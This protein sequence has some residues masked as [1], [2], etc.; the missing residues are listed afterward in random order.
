[1]VHPR[2]RSSQPS[3]GA[4]VILPQHAGP[5]PFFEAFKQGMRELGYVKGQNLT[6]DYRASEDRNQIITMAAEL[7]QLKVEAIVTQGTATRIA[8]SAIM[9]LPVVFGFS[10]DPIEAGFV[11]SL[12]RPGTNMTG[13]SFLS[14][15]GGLISY[16]PNQSNS[17]HRLSIFVDKILKGAKPADLPI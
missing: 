17:L 8:K 16:G 11:E 6:T 3:C 15:E 5:S 13:M 1:L 9:S 2:R 10:G 14:L 4:W 7:M 12:A